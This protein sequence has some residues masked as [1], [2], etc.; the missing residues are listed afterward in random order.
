MISVPTVLLLE[1]EGNNLESNFLTV[2]SHFPKPSQGKVI[3][4]FRSSRLG[5]MW[6]L[7]RRK[8]EMWLPGT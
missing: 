5:K 6:A 2:V 7:S 8:Q 4:G 3:S 1:M